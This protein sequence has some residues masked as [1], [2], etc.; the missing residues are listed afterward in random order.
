M[1][2]IFVMLL[3]ALAA[4]ATASAQYKGTYVKNT[5]IPINVIR[6]F[7]QIIKD[8]GDKEN[9]IYRLSRNPNTDILES[10]VQV[11]NFTCGV[12][13]HCHE[14]IAS[15]FMQDEPMSY[16]ISHITPGNSATFSIKVIEENGKVS[17]DQ[18]IRTE[19]NQEMW[20]MATKNPQNPQLRDVYA[21]VWQK[22]PEKSQCK[23]TIFMISS[24]RPDIYQQNLE[25]SSKTFKIEGRIDGEIKDSL[26]NVYIA[27]SYEELNSLADDDYVACVPVINKRFEYS[28]ELDKPKAGRIRC[29]FPDGSLC[30]AWINLDMVPGETYRITVHNGYYDEDRDYE[31]RVG[32]W[33]GKSLVAGHDNDDSSSPVV[34]DEKGNV[35]EFS[36][37]VQ[38]SNPLANLT[39][40]QKAA[41]D[42]KGEAIDARMQLV[43]KIYKDAITKQVNSTNTVYQNGKRK[44]VSD[45]D[46]FFEQIMKQNEQIDKQ[47]GDLLNT[48]NSY[49][50]EKQHIAKL[51]GRGMLEFLSEQNKAFIDLYGHFGSLSKVGT[52]CQK[53]VD[54]LTEKYLN[55]MSKLM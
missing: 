5:H 19:T 28:V 53:Q 45:M 12:G 35:V 13:S 34:L 2:K 16:Q 1:K 29:I 39:E 55:E 23:G 26:Y 3:I 47:F 32:R 43:K 7:D 11:V 52:K 36:P 37:A 46:T 51:I 18:R 38:T 6:D 30:S 41:I 48:A 14:T 22:V 25:N 42:A 4:V 20:Y 17:K 15:S 40:E 49:G 9:Q 33:S 8:N 21:I 44:E 31:Q 54:K 27:D 50:I 10:K 24:L